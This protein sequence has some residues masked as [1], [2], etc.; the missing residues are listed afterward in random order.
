MIMETKEL[1]ALDLEYKNSLIKF[2]LMM[3]ENQEMYSEGREYVMELVKEIL[4]GITK[5]FDVFFKK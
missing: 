5:D 2:A 4:E 1:K 3:L